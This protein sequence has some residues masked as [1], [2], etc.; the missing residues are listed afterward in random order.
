MQRRAAIY[1]RY[2]T[3]LQSERSI[4]DQVEL[5][6]SYLRREKYRLVQV[7][8]DKAMSSAT[9]VG[10]VGLAN[11]LEAARAGEID[12]LVVECVD[13][14]SRDIGDLQYVQKQ[15]SFAGVDIISA[16]EGVQSELQIGFRGLYGTMFLKDLREKVHRGMSGN[17]AK[18]LSA[19]GKAY[20]YSPISGKPGELQIEAHEA[21]VIR[22]IFLAYSKGASPRDIAHDLNA[23]GELPPRGSKWNASTLNGNKKRAYGILRNSLYAGILVWDRVKMV[24]DPTTGKRVSREKPAEDWKYAEVPHLRLI[25]EELW[26]AVQKRLAKQSENKRS[27]KSTRKPLRPFSGLLWCGCCGGGMSI[28][29]RKGSAIRLR[30]SAAKESGSCNNNGKVRL[31]KIESA[32][33]AELRKE[34]ST[35]TYINEFIRAYNEERRELNAAGKP[36]RKKLERTVAEANKLLSRRIELFEMGILEGV[37][38][39]AKLTEAKERASV[40]MDVLASFDEKERAFEFNPATASKYVTAL[41]EMIS[42]MQAH[43]GN[44]NPKARDAVRG[45]ISEI[46]V[47]PTEEDGVPVEV[48]GRLSALVSNRSKKVGG[49]VVAEEGLEPPTRGL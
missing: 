30:C 19:G 44:P 40:A 46:V 9:L 4:E 16:S 36:D 34:L 43:N 15:L 3:T 5:C 42:S 31:D 48:K 39:E 28:H 49:L 2:S 32:L 37:E 26:D 23:Q 24:R 25:D 41:D 11:L 7:F 13:R 21:K 38:G 20:G 18:G 6:R 1:A 17:I 35:P 45:L 47:S 14:I 22:R 29:D 10:R 33:L 8:E 27:G 12:A